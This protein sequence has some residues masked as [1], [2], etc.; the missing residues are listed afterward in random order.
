MSAPQDGRTPLYVAALKGK[1]A[2]ARVLMQA[3]ANKESLGPVRA[4]G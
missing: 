3:E 4:R 1:V 2:V